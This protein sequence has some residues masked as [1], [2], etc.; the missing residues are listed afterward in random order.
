MQ[1]THLALAPNG[2]SGRFGNQLFLV[3]ST[4]GIALNNN[5]KYAF[6]EWKNNIYFKKKLP[7]LAPGTGITYSEPSFK[8]TPVNF[9]DKQFVYLSGYFQSPKY[10]Q[11]YEDTIRETFEFKDN[12]INN[13][14]S[15]L[16]EAKLGTT[17]S[18]HVRR[19]D[20]LNYT[21][22]H[23][24]QPAEY[25]SSAQKV[26]EDHENINTYVVFSDDINWCKQN[27]QLFNTTGKR[28]VFMQGRNEI[29]DFIGMMYCDHNIITNSTF[30]WWAAWLNTN[31]NKAVV[32]PKLWFGPKG[33]PDS[34]DLQVEGWKII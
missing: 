6:P 19:G 24:Q 9:T 1:V 27:K 3:A 15:V 21:D 12:F 20:Y 8:Y 33:P 13:V 32:M 5:M 17:C 23:P 11:N 25:W 4:I 10:F 30:S 2:N 7:Q 22:I 26:I 31:K 29:D 14:K 18:I 16:D 28:V 34:T